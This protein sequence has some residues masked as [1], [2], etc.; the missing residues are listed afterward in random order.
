MRKGFLITIVL[1]LVAYL[2]LPLPGL[3]KSLQ[4]QI[5]DTQHKIDGK[6]AHENVLTTEIASYGVRIKSLQGDITELQLRQDRVQRELDV[7][8]AELNSI[9]NRLQIVQDRLTRLRKKLAA[10]R[11]LLATR[12]VALYKDEE[13]DMV[14]VVL[15]A[16]GFTDLL[17]RS[18]YLDRISQQNND[19]VARVKTTTHE[20]AVETDRLKVLEGQAVAAANAITA[21][22]NEIAGAKQTLVNRQGD[23][24]QARDVRSRAVDQ[25]RS[26]RH[27]LEGHLEVLQ[28]KQD[29]IAARLAG[30]S[31]TVSGGPI[32]H[33]SGNFIWPVNG[34]IVSPFGMR[35][36]RMHEGVDIA[37]GSGTPIHAAAAGTVA[38]MQPESASGGYGNYTCVQHSGSLSTCYAHQSRFGTSVGA[39]VSQGQVIGYSGCTG[40]C[41]GPHVHFEVRVNGSPVDPLGYL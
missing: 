13:P 30:T 31:G 37:V 23:L 29:Q 1:G 33:G 8:Q 11:D 12:L 22:R 24:K 15:E 4:G 25:I 20:V 19:I 27:D 3:S 9:R 41:F 38:L 18:E 7:K 32:R 28:K 26:A 14:T 35:W 2:A 36:G 40:H 10:D 16:H 21:K 39:H 6:K 5:G 34:P 17:D